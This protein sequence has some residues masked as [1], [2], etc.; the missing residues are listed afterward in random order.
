MHRVIYPLTAGL[1]TILTTS[2]T[3]IPARAQ[4]STPS[5]PGSSGIVAR[6]QCSVPNIGGGEIAL[7]GNGY[8]KFQEENGKYET[9]SG[10]YRF[11]SSSLR[12]QSA[13]RYKKD[14]YM[15]PTSDEVKAIYL[16]N[17][18]EI[19]PCQAPEPTETIRRRN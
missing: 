6:F 19:K 14:I 1:L 3:T 11:L 10:G 13:I 16:I 18:D 15:F 17:S 8:Y 7:R 5:T 4:I 2:L 12:G 9:I